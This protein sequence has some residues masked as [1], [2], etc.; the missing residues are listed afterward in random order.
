MDQYIQAK[1]SDNFLIRRPL[2]IWINLFHMALVKY[3]T[4]MEI[5]TKASLKMDMLMAGVISASQTKLR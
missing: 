1:L 5:H 4:S 2:S 3:A